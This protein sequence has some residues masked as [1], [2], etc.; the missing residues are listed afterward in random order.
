[1]HR[2]FAT[3]HHGS[4]VVI[5]IGTA[6]KTATI[7]GASLCDVRHNGMIIG[8][9]SGGFVGSSNTASRAIRRTVHG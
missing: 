9:C 3:G 4:V 6:A 5:V 7:L 1:M 2:A 8:C